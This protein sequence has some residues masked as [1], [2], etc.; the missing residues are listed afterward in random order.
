[1]KYPLITD[2]FLWDIVYPLFNSAENVL[3]FL[4]SNRYKRINILMGNE[5]P[6][7]KKYKKE[8]NNK[9]FNNLVYYLKKN[10]YIKSK[11][12]ESKEAIV[13]TSR[14]IDKIKKAY[15]KESRKEI[16]KRKDRKWIMIVFDIPQ[17]QRRKRNL[18]RSVLQ[19]LGYKI[20]QQSVWVTPYNVLEKTEKLLQ[21]YSLEDYTRIFLIERI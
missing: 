19:N 7:I 2:Q 14:G 15:L 12:L 13:L 21:F 5:N 20:F 3:D 17:N 11:K 1:M 6:I 16:E 9:R 10:N 8:K 18:L 4:L